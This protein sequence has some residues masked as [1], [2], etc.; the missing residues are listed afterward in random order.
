MSAV[1]ASSAASGSVVDPVR[2]LQHALYR[3]AKA[4]PGRRFHA[5]GDKVHSQGRPG[6]RVGGRA[7]SVDPVE[8]YNVD[9]VRAI[10]TAAGRHSNGARW[11]IA[12]ALGLRQGEV[13]GL[14]WSDVNLDGGFLR[15]RSTRH[16]P[17]YPT[18]A[19]AP[20][21][22]RPAGARI[23]SKLTSP[24]GKPLNPN[25]DYHRWKA[26]LREAGV[27]DG[28]LHDARHTAAT[29]VLVLGVPERTVMGIM[30]WSSTSM[31][32]R[33]QHVTDPIRQQGGQPGRRSVVDR[34][35]DP[36]G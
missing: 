35:T 23:E 29:V 6:A 9:E 27:R 5:L 19:M 13:L 12:L 34:Q 28:R 10:L 30:G 2:A 18:V 22:R 11:A 14:T 3:A 24:V 31:A 15:V 1:S 33:Y 32:A 17:T 8:P 20:A 4:D 36:F 21:A 25:S 16:R 26:L 7:R